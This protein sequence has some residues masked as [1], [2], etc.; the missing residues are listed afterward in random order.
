M[1][2]TTRKK[3]PILYVKTLGLYS[4]ESAIVQKVRAT[5]A[6]HGFTSLRNAI[7]YLLEH[8][9]VDIHHIAF[10]LDDTMWV[11]TAA[12]K[13]LQLLEIS[14]AQIRKKLAEI[15]CMHDNGNQIDYQL[16]DETEVLLDIKKKQIL[17]VIAKL[18]YLWLP[19]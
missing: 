9:R 10:S 7:R 6:M 11:L 5:M 8:R 2:P 17:D 15:N 18:S 19:K 14:I 12:R 3:R 4:L 1:T 13:D 16:F